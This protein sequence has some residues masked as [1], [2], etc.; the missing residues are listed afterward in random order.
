MTTSFSGT[1]PSTQVLEH[2]FLEGLAL[3][4]LPP[5]DRARSGDLMASPF[6]E[7][8]RQCWPEALGK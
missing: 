1:T 8:G 2:D 7:G 3:A 4:L 6:F 5:G